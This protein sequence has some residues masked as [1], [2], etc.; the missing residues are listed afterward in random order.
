[1]KK[2]EYM[3]PEMEVIKI[4]VENAMLTVSTGEGQGGTGQEF[5]DDVE[6]G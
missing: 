6:P 1:M 5:D 3:A 2:I 4:Q